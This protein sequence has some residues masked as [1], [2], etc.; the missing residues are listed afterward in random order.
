MENKDVEAIATFL[1]R[2][3]GQLTEAKAM[4]K[5]NKNSIEKVL[6]SD[7]EYRQKKDALTGAKNDVKI[8][9]YQLLNTAENKF[10]LERKEEYRDKVK[11]LQSALSD[12]LS[13][14]ARETGETQ[15]KLPSGDVVNIV[16]KYSIKSKQMRLFY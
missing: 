1:P 9:T 7:K 14:Y 5:G 15:F 13:T 10:L 4:A 3:V 16:S 8:K 11:E 12:Y 2:L 6:D